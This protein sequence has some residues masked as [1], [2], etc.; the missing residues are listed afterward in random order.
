M[1]KF[2]LI[3]FF[4]ISIGIL[5]RDYCRARS[6]MI[7]LPFTSQIDILANIDWMSTGF[8]LIIIAVV[9]IFGYTCFSK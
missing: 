9:L 4:I 3:L 6:D 7:I 5:V 2:F 8:N 1:K